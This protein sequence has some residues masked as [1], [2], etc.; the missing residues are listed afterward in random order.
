M[1]GR[2]GTNDGPRA[3]TSYLMIRNY[4]SMEEVTSRMHG[5]TP[6]IIA[7][8]DTIMSTIIMPSW[9]AYPPAQESQVDS[10]G[11]KATLGVMQVSHITETATH[12][13]QGC[14]RGQG[15]CTKSPRCYV[16]GRCPGPAEERVG[17]I[18][19]RPASRYQKYCGSRIWLL[20][21]TIACVW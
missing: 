5:S 12:I 1:Q 14:F 18:R 4:V 6:A 3:F 21:K 19:R 2:K 7:Y 9:T 17:G 16:P 10:A 15:G 8:P 13:I 11:P 20:L